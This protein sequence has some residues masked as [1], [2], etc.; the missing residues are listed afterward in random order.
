M[1]RNYSSQ[2]DSPNSGG[3]IKSKPDDTKKKNMD[4]LIKVNDKF[5]SLIDKVCIFSFIKFIQLLSYLT[6]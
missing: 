4:S 2:S 3:P 1:S 6:D 5:V